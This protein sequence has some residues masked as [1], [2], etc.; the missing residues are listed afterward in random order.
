MEKL[1][2]TIWMAAMKMIIYTESKAMIDW[3]AAVEM[4]YSMAAL[5]TT[6]SRAAKATT[7]SSL[8]QEMMSSMDT[9]IKATTA[10]HR[11]KTP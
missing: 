4:T 7:P 11:L 9:P 5:A 3:Q 6:S 8:L 2:T 10:T 1:A